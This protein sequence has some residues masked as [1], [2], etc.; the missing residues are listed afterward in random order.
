VGSVLF[1]VGAMAAGPGAPFADSDVAGSIG[2]CNQAGQQITSGNVT[3]QP[4]AWRAV[5]TEPA[6]AP[7]NDASRTATLV[8]YQPQ[9]GLPAGDWSGAQMTSSSRYSNPANPMA[10]ATTADQ[11]LQDIIEQ[12]PPKWDGFLQLRIYLGTANQE[13][14]DQRYPALDIE[15]TGD[16][17]Q[18][19][20]GSPVNC[21]SGTAVSLESVLLPSSST[22][23]TA[24]TTTTSSTSA[25][26]SAAG[27]GASGGRSSGAGTSSAGTRPS[28]TKGGSGDQV[29]ASGAPAGADASRSTHVPLIVGL[30]L[31]VVVV[32]ATSWYLLL[33][34]RRL[35]SLAVDPVLSSQSSSTT[36]RSTKGDAS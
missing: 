6:Q 17:W 34:R 4:F 20:G 25:V 9:Q 1:T 10:A 19:I 5:S 3:A 21:A 11:S 26:A 16:T 14:Y 13:T 15:V 2:L 8:A 24:P 18:A 32:L 30:A 33:R 29:L 12:Y 36:S 22:T 31:A 28:P 35:A 23:T 7:Y 27:K